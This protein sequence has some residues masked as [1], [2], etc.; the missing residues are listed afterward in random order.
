M[1]TASATFRGHGRLE[2]TTC[3]C[4]E[5]SPA[6]GMKILFGWAPPPPARA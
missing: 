1:V 2:W 4:A 5:A 6:R 3:W